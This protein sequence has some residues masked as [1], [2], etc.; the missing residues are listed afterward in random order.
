MTKIRLAQ[1]GTG[2]ET[3][4]LAF[5]AIK[6]NATT[7]ATGVVE[8]ATDAETITGSDTTRAMT[9]SNLTAK[10][11]TDVTLSG[12]SDTRIASQKAV[13]AYADNLI[14][15]ANALVYKAVIDCSANPNYP[16][17]DA[18]WLYIVSVAGKIG[19][20]S[21]TSVDVG[22]MLICNTD[23]TVSGNQATV[24]AY[25]NIIERN[26]VGAVSGPASATDGVF[27][28]FDGTTGKLL[29]NATPRSIYGNNFDGSGSLTQIIAS[30]YGG[31]GNGF[32]KFTGPTTAERT[33]TLPDAS[34]TIVV[35]GGALGT[36][37]S[38][39]VTNLTG[40][41]SININGTVG[42]TTPTTGAFTTLSAGSL[43]IYR[44]SGSGITSG[45]SLQTAAGAVGD[46]SYIKWTG[47]VEGEKIALI[48]GVQGG[49]DLGSLRFSTGNG[50]D[51]FAERMRIDNNGN[52]GIGVTAP[53]AKLEVKVL[54][55]GTVTDALVLSNPAASTVGTGVALHFQPNGQGGLART[56]KIVSRQTTT[57]NYADL[58]FFVAPSDTPFEALTITTAG[59]VGIGQTTPTAALH[60]KAGNASASS[61]PIKLTSGVVNTTAEAG[62]V[63]YNNTLHFT[64][65]DNTRRHVVLAPN[66]TKVTASAPYTNDGYVVVNIGG[67][68]FKVMT[69]A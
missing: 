47:A 27:A 56:A 59:R 68:D 11:D 31:T 43:S 66:A 38:G 67:T 14:A 30:T 7:S 2:Q 4:A 45:I 17:A 48:E 61:A 49:T 29:K 13:K 40:T 16:A 53:A 58:G 37:L 15:V 9:P 22:D 54:S 28:V 5:D 57:G 32:T 39:T 18:G 50:A 21:G 52:V 60:I 33:F 44:S 64:N 69:T 6:Q 55:A 19:G 62:A 41:A 23:S 63:E 51:A 36:P 26:I 20:A 65:S 12:N 8:L 34:S 42:A 46:G 35:Q 25:W 3:A 1:G 10:I 24:G